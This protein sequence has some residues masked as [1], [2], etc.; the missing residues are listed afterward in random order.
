MVVYGDESAGVEAYYF[1]SVVYDVS[2]T[3]E[4]A[5]L[6]EFFFG[7]FDGGG[8]AEAESAAV[9]DFYL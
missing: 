7:F 8:Y 1:H 2:E 3:V 9:V 5:S 4:C 6:L